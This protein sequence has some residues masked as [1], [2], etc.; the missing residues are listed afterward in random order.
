[1]RRNG[2]DLLQS[3]ATGINS[4][5]RIV[6]WSGAT[7]TSSDRRAVF[8]PVYFTGA[9]WR[10]LNDRHFAFGQPTGWVLQA[11]MAINSGGTIAGTGINNSGQTRGF[12]LVPRID[13]Q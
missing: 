4:L 3:E 2:F 9:R 10:D 6:G 7:S 8:I 5:L 11:A 13:G 12:L 1:L